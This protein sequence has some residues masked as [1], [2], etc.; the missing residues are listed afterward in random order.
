MIDLLYGS[1]HVYYFFHENIFFAISYVVHV[2]YWFNGSVWYYAIRWKK[3][4]N[5]L[6]KLVFSCY[7]ASTSSI[8]PIYL[9]SSESKHPIK[10]KDVLFIGYQMSALSVPIRY[11]KIFVTAIRYDSFGLAWNHAHR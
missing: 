7:C 2:F 4:C 10:L 8:I 9:I 11:I 5:L 1:R 3:K 6:N